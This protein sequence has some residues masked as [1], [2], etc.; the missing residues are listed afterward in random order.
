MVCILYLLKFSRFLFILLNKS[1]LKKLILILNRVARVDESGR[2]PRK[3][4]TVEPGSWFAIVSH[5]T[6]YYVM[7]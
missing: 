3:Y 2:V 5:V 6:D 7:N 4:G 1:Y